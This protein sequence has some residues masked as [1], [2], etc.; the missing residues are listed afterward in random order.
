M[1]SNSTRRGFLGR[2]LLAGAAFALRRLVSLGSWLRRPLAPVAARAAV[3]AA[4]DAGSPR[5]SR[6]THG[7][8]L[9]HLAPTS[10]RVWAR[11][12]N[13]GWYTL[14]VV[15]EHG[16]VV[17]TAE[18]TPDR[19]YTMVWDV[20]GLDPGGRYAY[21]VRQG[22][23]EDARTIF[24]GEDARFVTPLPQTAPSVTRLAVGSCAREEEGD[25]AV[26][27]RMA[28]LDPHA[29]VLLGDTPYIDST[30]LA[31]QHRRY[32]EFAAVPEFTALLRARPLYATWDDHD[33]GKNDTNGLLDGKEN[34]RQ[35]FV[36]YR[37]NASCGD[38]TEGVYTSFRRGG[39]E[40]FLL[41]TRWFAGTGPSPIA[42]GPTMLGR[43][44]WEWLRDGLRA[45]D[46]PFKIL[47]SGLIWNGAVRPGKPD[48]WDSYP[49]EKE[50][51]WRFLGEERISGVVLMGGDIHR[52]RVLRY[53]T[54]EI[55]GYALTELVT[56][57]IH[58]GV[59]DDANAPH[60]A[61]VFDSGT[62]HSFMLMT[63]DTTLDPP[64]LHASFQDA[65][66]REL[67]ALTLDAA[68]LRGA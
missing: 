22:D 28:S 9:G 17:A 52:T 46:A 6:L 47:A 15:G 7:P 37:A 14:A 56:S 3:G 20:A 66:G 53:P 68:E 40:F 64:T 16:E 21:E 42:D 31:V 55:V 30:D 62:P 48:H 35:A 12:E 54:E 45:S 49:A 63:V 29:L 44:Q 33:F 39:V 59:I 18:A 38:G 58:A 8:L 32:R 34:A 41:D 60:P 23:G 13:A 61:L 67:Y 25:R 65:T 11:G 10:V 4:V 24:S 50:A 1:N 19:D 27:R 26:W 5:T 2:T 51:L 57:P 43:Q 36:H